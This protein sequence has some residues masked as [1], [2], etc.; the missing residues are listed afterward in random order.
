MKEILVEGS[1]IVP[2]GSLNG[3]GTTRVIEPFGPGPPVYT[4]D[5]VIVL[6]AAPEVVLWPRPE[7]VP[8]SVTVPPTSLKGGGTISV[9]ERFIVEP[10]VKIME[11][12]VLVEVVS[13]PEVKVAEVLEVAP[14]D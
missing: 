6:C 12:P 4:V 13:V 5:P 2:P 1:L 9:V 10:P 14:E 3:G 8:V 7:V 11:A